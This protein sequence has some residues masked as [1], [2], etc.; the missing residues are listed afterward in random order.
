[1]FNSRLQSLHLSFSGIYKTKTRLSLI[2]AYL[3]P[4]LNRFLLLISRALA[5]SRFRMYIL[6]AR[7]GGFGAGA[8]HHAVGAHDVVFGLLVVDQQLAVLA[9][10]LRLVL[11][12]G[13][14]I[15]PAFGLAEDGVDLFE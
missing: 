5:A 7:G 8:R 13:D 9:V 1:M 3:P 4:F 14:D 2:T 10:A 11:G 15:E 6:D 12:D